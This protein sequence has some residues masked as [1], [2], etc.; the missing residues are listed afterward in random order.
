MQVVSQS[1]MDAASPAWGP[2]D[3]GDI[4]SGIVDHVNAGIDWRY[5]LLTV[6]REMLER[7]SSK[8]SLESFYDFRFAGH[9]TS[10]VASHE[11]IIL[12]Q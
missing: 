1:L 12:T 2:T 8:I 11:R 5:E 4:S 7:R 6:A 10:S 9:S 3:M